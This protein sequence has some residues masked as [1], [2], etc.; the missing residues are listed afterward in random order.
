MIKAIRDEIEIKGSKEDILIDLV[1]IISMVKLK[2]PELEREIRL[3]IEIGMAAEV[4][5]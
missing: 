4:D 2:M 1:C 5:E 3:A